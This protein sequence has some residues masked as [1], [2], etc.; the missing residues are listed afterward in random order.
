MNLITGFANKGAPA[1]SRG[2]AMSDGPDG[3]A[4]LR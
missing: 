4:L 3:A 2:A 1:Q